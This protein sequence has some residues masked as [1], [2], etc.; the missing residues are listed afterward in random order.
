MVNQNFS[1]LKINLSDCRPVVEASGLEKSV[2]FRVQETLG[3]GVR[4]VRVLANQVEGE[5]P[6]GNRWV[7][8]EGGRW[9]PS[10]PGGVGGGEEEERGQRGGARDDRAAEVERLCGRGGGGGDG[11]GGG[12]HGA[13]V[14][15][16]RRPP[17]GA[18]GHLGQPVEKVNVS[19]RAFLGNSYSSF[20]YF[21][22]SFHSS[23]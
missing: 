8:E 22:I 19:T 4:V 3:E 10:S 6:G 13:T 18:D 17:S 15:R 9:G 5:E 20:I 21:F 12:C 23:I 7:G 1:G 16:R 2:I 11:D 14:V